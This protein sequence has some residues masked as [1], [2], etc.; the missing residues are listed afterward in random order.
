MIQREHILQKHA[1]LWAREAIAVEHEFFAFDRSKPFGQFTHMREKARGIKKATPDTLLVAFG[2]KRRI[3]CEYKA[4][5]ETPTDDQFRMGER[6]IALGDAWVWHTTVCT[7]R[8][9]LLA[10]GVP[11]RPS[12]EFLAIHHDACVQGE[13]E[14]AEIK[15]GQVP[16]RMRVT[17]PKPTAAAIRRAHQAGMW[18]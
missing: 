1:R 15:A 4:P 10:F 12:A 16:K 9:S 2:V 13:I 18:K 11:L 3:W 17:A 8:L 5:G 14:R 7:Y 6:L